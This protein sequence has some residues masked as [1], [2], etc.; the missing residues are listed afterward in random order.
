MKK[1]KKR[2]IKNLLKK[3]DIVITRRSKVQSKVQRLVEKAIKNIR[4][5]EDLEFLSKLPDEQIPYFLKNLNKSKSQLRQ[6]FFV[7]SQLKFKK[8]GYFVEFGATNGMDLSN[9]YLLE[10]EFGW[11]GILAEPAKCWHDDLEKNR[12]CH[13]DTRC[14]WNESNLLLKFNEVYSAEFSTI[15]KFSFSD[16]HMEERKTGEI[17]EVE[18]VSL[19]GLLEN[20][21]APEKIDYLSIDTEGSEY[22]I[23]RNF[24]FD[25]YT[26]Q[27][28]TCEHNYG[29]IREEIHELLYSKGYVRLLE[30]VSH[31]DDWY[32]KP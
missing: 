20:Y 5:A 25:K 10:N 8:N 14:V 23:L 6:D 19:L 30:D 11:D 24:D 1:H 13:I 3:C 12:N 31:I 17:Y 28:I 9:T 18:T 4:P 2:P 32:V 15:E 29:P 7:L 27:I 22:E 21:N 16:R 26:F